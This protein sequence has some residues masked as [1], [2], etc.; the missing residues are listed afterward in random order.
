MAKLLLCLL[1]MALAQFTTAQ[2]DKAADGYTLKY[3]HDLDS[4]ASE[5]PSLKMDNRG[6]VWFATTTGLCRFDGKNLSHFTD[7]ATKEFCILLDRHAAL[8]DSYHGQLYFA[9]RH[10]IWQYKPTPG[11]VLKKVEQFND[12]VAIKSM[13]LM[14]SAQV[15]LTFA[16]QPGL[17]LVQNGQLR[18]IGNLKDKGLQLQRAKQGLLYALADS[19]YYVFN[20]GRVI[21]RIRTRVML[22]IVNNFA[23]EDDIWAAGE[24]QLYKLGVNGLQDSIA[25]L[26]HESY[27]DVIIC[28]GIKQDIFYFSIPLNIDFGNEYDIL[29]LEKKQYKKILTTSFLFDLAQDETGSLWLMNTAGLCR[30]SKTPFYKVANNF[31]LLRFGIN[32]VGKRIISGI[33]IALPHYL[34][35]KGI[36]KQWWARN[37]DRWY[38]TPKG[39]YVLVAKTQRYIYY[40]GNTDYIMNEDTTGTIWFRNNASKY[41]S[42]F[43]QDK[44]THL[45][46]SKW[47]ND[48]RIVDV[49]SNGKVN[50]NIISNNLVFFD[51]KSPT[52]L[53]K[54]LYNNHISAKFSTDAN[55][56]LWMLINDQIYKIGIKTDGKI[57]LSDSIPIAHAYDITYI[58]F[59]HH[60][61]LWATSSHGLKTTYVFLCGADGRLITDPIT[62]SPAFPNNIGE[63]SA[64]A[65]SQMYFVKNIASDNDEVFA[66]NTDSAIDAY[67]KNA[68]VLHGPYLTDISIFNQPYVNPRNTDYDNFGMPVHPT[69]T[70]QQ[71]MLTFRCSAVSPSFPET[72]VYQYRLQGLE[73]DW[74]PTTANNEVEYNNLAPGRYTL[75]VRAQDFRQRWT[76]SIAYPFYVLPPWYRTWWAYTLW[77]CLLAGLVALL[78]FLR[79][80]AIRKKDNMDRMLTEQQ[81]KALRAQIDPHFLQNSFELI[82]RRIQLANVQGTLEA[83]HKVSAYIRKVLYRTDKSTATLEEELE[84]INEYLAVQQTL[85]DNSF[86]YNIQVDAEVDVFGHDMPSLLLQP[87]VENA[88]K[89]GIDHRLKTGHIAIIVSQDDRFIY[90]RITDGGSSLTVLQKEKEYRPKGLENAIQRLMLM[91]KKGKN[92][93]SVAISA[94]AMGGHTVTVALPLT[95]N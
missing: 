84:F 57:G 46:V 55:D 58:E 93:P 33:D 43:R 54:K 67:T 18:N 88:I 50:G 73:N 21:N 38:C 37:G 59:D 15:W 32:G 29:K 25:L 85:M 3:Y 94:N 62:L 20:E 80:H 45:D 70:Y 42:F 17:W 72:V 56:Q 23:E 19:G 13:V 75:L 8:I 6:F 1:M 49:I 41:I 47:F 10:Q 79:L 92:K 52:P 12:S 68:A 71:N 28:K 95:L 64:C 2:E 83:L 24:R 16:N 48:D 89:H 90:C 53:F 61:N 40:K 5:Q 81:L 44:F 35:S 31:N 39:L 30:L 14:D 69:F 34:Q 87:I 77:C 7:A 76:A 63:P 26:A 22:G 78:F 91:Y 60:N 86:A 51:N 11:T 74:R 36:T 65:G 82:G 9:S 27:S 4:L 66:I